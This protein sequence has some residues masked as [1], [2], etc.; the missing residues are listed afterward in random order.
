MTNGTE[1]DELTVQ[2][3]DIKSAWLEFATAI[4]KTAASAV[5]ALKMLTRYHNRLVISAKLQEVH[6]PDRLA[7]WL[8][9]DLL[10]DWLIDRLSSG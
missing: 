1:E 9:F 2:N 8:A 6:C 10:P 3:R 4:A 5:Q 7:S